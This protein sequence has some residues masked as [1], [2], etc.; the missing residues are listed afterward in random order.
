MDPSEDGR[1]DIVMCGAILLHLRDPVLALERIRGVCDGTLILVE[2]VDPKLELLAPRY[3]SAA[4]RPYADQWWVPNSPGMER[5]L[6]MAG[7]DVVQRCKR[8]LFPYG[9]AGP[10]RMDQS[11]LT[12]IAARKPGRRGILGRIWLAQAR[13]L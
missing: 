7:W 9:P 12:G 10:S 11:W 4:V 13:P 5:M 2:L 8:F 3:P 1:F 6:H